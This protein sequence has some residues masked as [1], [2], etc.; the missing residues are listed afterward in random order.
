MNKCFSVAMLLFWGFV[1]Q[2]QGEDP[3]ILNGT[4]FKLSCNCYRLTLPQVSQSGSVW[5]ENQ[6]SLNNPFDFTFDVFLGNN[7]GG[8][9]GIAFVLQPISTQVGSV[10]GGLGYEG[11]TPSIAVEIDTYQNAN[12]PTF[13]HV[14]IMSNGVVNHSTPNN[15]A[16][17]VGALANNGNIENNQEHLLRV[18][19]EPVAQLMQVYVDGLLRVSYTGDIIADI[20]S[21]DSQ[22]FWGFTGSTGGLFNE[23]RFCLSIIPG[24]EITA[25]Q[26]CAG[27]SVNVIDD[28]YSAL[29]EVVEWQWD[30]GNGQTSQAN[31][32]GQV[33]YA[34]PGIYSIVQTIIDAAGCTAT[35]AVQLTVVANPT[36]AF[37]VQEVCVG[38][39]TAFTDLSVANQGTLAQ[40]A[41]EFGVADETS[42]LR[43]PLQDY[44]EAGTYEVTLTVTSSNGCVDSITAPV[45]VNSLPVADLTQSAEGFDVSFSTLMD[46]GETAQWIFP[47]TTIL[48][49]EFVLAFADSGWY[50]VQL[51]VTNAAGCTD[52][53]F[54][55]FYL[56][57]LPD[58]AFSNVFTPNG[59]DMNEVFAPYTY[60]IV[61]ASI[62]VFNRWGRSVHSFEGA[63]TSADTWGWDGKINGGAE[64]AAGTYYFMID[65]LGA[66]GNRFN[67]H[68]AVTLVR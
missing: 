45:V 15:L 31:N 66:D 14:A 9:D 54:H 12:D 18:V 11:I 34:Q 49:P 50:S 55:E 3:Y 52:T 57:G 64:A 26:I 36:A 13:D 61:E 24:M 46:D 48:S 65:L 62:K 23:Q 37:S 33:V 58:Y 4:A 22:V 40:W 19:W 35:D 8:A 60:N 28:S 63:I 39:P 27:D 56:E 2:A 38:D 67:R 5:N 53:I 6:I 51:V 17:P 21:G 32:P 7:D 10:G 59:D 42:S 29:G 68:G 1:A 47:D 41:W 30:F 25:P 44:A 16:G 20:F 43:N